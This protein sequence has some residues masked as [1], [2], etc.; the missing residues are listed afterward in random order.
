MKT[1]PYDHVIARVR[2]LAKAGTDLDVADTRLAHQTAEVGKATMRITLAAF[3]TAC[4][5]TPVARSTS[6]D[7]TPIS[8]K[9]RAVGDVPSGSFVRTGRESHEFLVS[10][11]LFRGHNQTSDELEIG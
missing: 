5:G 9:C 7:G 11:S 8:V 1:H 2:R 3:V 10:H 6:S 4:A